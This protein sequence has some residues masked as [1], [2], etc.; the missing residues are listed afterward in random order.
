MANII[1][2]RGEAL[3]APISCGVRRDLAL[4]SGVVQVSSVHT[5]FIFEWLSRIL[6]TVYIL[7]RSIQYCICFDKTTRLALCCF[8]FEFSTEDLAGFREEVNRRSWNG[9]RD[10]RNV[11]QGETALEQVNGSG[12]YHRPS[13]WS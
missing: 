13:F 10:L 5:G 9:K 7:Y 11:P 8:E 1:H 6:I 2:L 4:E 12:A 3:A